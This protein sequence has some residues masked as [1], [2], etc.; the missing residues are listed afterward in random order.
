ML[1]HLVDDHGRPEGGDREGRDHAV[2]PQVAAEALHTDSEEEPER[3]VAHRIEG[4]IEG[5][6]EGRDRD[7]VQARE[8]EEV[9]EV[10]DAPEQ[11]RGSEEKPR[12]ALRTDDVASCETGGARSEEE[13][14]V[15]PGVEEAID[16][17]LNARERL[18]RVDAGHCEQGSAQQSADAKVRPDRGRPVISVVPQ[19]AV[20][21]V[22]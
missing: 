13:P 5:I 4:E 16:A 7:L 19:A 2:E 9:V 14:V 22:V 3:D 11:Q 21:Q 10:A 1:D 6:T 8:K 15:D 18:D 12:Q 17:S 20:L